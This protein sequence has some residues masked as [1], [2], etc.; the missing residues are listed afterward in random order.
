[1]K[2]FQRHVK[3]LYGAPERFS[4]G[5][6]PSPFT[7]TSYAG[8]GPRIM[9]RASRTNRGT[10]DRCSIAVYNMS[11]DL[12]EQMHSD[13]E[14][15]RER[16]KDI[17]GRRRFG[18]SPAAKPGGAGQA[19]ESVAAVN[20]ERAR[21]LKILSDDY[22]VNLFVG[23]GPDE[24]DLQLLF[25]GDLLSVSPRRRNGADTIT[26]IE[27][28]DTL[29]ALRDSFS[30][31]IYQQGA[32]AI[33]AIVGALDDM[34]VEH[35]SETQIRALLPNAVLTR[36]KNGIYAVGRSADTID[37][38]VDLFGAQWWVKDGRFE[39]VP[40]NGTLK[41][42]SLELREGVDLLDFG[43]RKSYGDSRGR[44]LLN[45]SI[46]PG[47]GM[48]IFREDGEPFDPYGHRVNAVLYSGDTRGTAW[49]ADF[50]AVTM[51][52][53]LS[54]PTTGE[55]LPRDYEAGN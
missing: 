54:A 4:Q 43:E 55:F 5:H 12:R 17:Q 22:R 23:Y 26:T 47:R 20:R 40:Q 15:L 7:L 49:Y 16:R 3:L 45:A 44:A 37:E 52:T 29:L 41:D 10:P 9:F 39:I 42:F 11:E 24:D 53:A 1:M 33:N 38:F 8:S 30:A 51:P 48:R 6:G 2:Q 46:V 50:E 36:Q 31:S 27:L 28:G 25:R 19:W 34:G 21:L 14:E 32:D 13:A 35:D 18:T